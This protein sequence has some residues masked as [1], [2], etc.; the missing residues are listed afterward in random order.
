MPNYK[1][2]SRRGSTWTATASK[3]SGDRRIRWSQGGFASAKEAADKR[4]E[5][6]ASI[7]EGSYVPPNELT[8]GG[9]LGDWLDGLAV[10]GRRPTTVSSYQRLANRWLIPRLGKIL[11]QDLGPHDIDRLYGVMA[12]TVKLRTVRFAHAVLRKALDDAVRKQLRRTNP[13]DLASPP[14]VSATR[15][16]EKMVWTPEQLR[17]FL[18]EHRDNYYYP[19]WHLLGFTGMRRGEACGLMWD[20]VDLDSGSLYVH[21][22][23]TTVESRPVWGVVK[24][25]RSRRR[26]ALDKATVDVLRRHRKAQAA[27]RLLL[28]DGWRDSGCVF[29]GPDGAALHPDSAG[30]AFE[31][32]AVAA[33][34]RSRLTMHGL[35]HSHC[36]H[37]L[38]A[39]V[40]VKTVSERLG[41]TSTAFTLDH[42]GHVL[43]GSQDAAAA[44]VAKL[45]NPTPSDHRPDRSAVA[46]FAVNPKPIA[47]LKGRQ[48]R[49]R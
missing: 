33:P 45:V 2:V 8:V 34:G 27:Q 22:T 7:A 1:G 23:L 11:L 36:T 49:T 44:A 43:P 41:H 38:V 14:K 9:Y 42:Y 20:A 17:D 19:L 4:A 29:T 31:R 10:S 24:T 39:G 32:A 13:A 37:L 26:I 12:E 5:M 25:G 3:G 47:G 35:R 40:D 46:N 15:A 48:T 28:G 6:L 16:P 30:Q 18:A 21:R